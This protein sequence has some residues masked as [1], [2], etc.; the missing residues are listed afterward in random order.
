MELLE[1]EDRPA[2]VRFERRPIELKAESLKQGRTVYKDVD[3]VI[4]TPPYSR[5]AFEDKAENWLEKQRTNV[6]TGRIPEK[7]LD[8]WKECY[9]KWKIGQ[10]PPVNGTDIRNWSAV[11]PAEIKTMQSIG[12]R[13][14]ED[15][16]S[17]N[18]EGLNRL[19]MGGRKLKDLAEAWV[20]SADDRGSIVMENAELKKQL[21]ISERDNETLRNQIK[22][23]KYQL[24][25]SNV[26]S[27]SGELEWNL[28]QE[29]DITADDILEPSLKDQVLEREE[30]EKMYKERFGRKAAS[31]MT[32]TSIRNKLGI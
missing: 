12:I 31:N 26:V 21:D 19:G 28:R 4:V 1:R 27:H 10:E 23:L 2:Y 6:R 18:A 3:W 8:F 16:A 7:F 17:C 24:E 5:D 32:V 11:S 15:M 22:T 13:T 30:L 20:K 9:E 29:E 25:N 14:I